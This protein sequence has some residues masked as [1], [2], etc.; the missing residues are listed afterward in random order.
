MLVSHLNN[1][2]YAFII[3][4]IITKIRDCIFLADDGG[5]LGA[6]TNGKSHVISSFSKDYSVKFYI[7]LD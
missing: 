4:G 5:V 6:H 7:G 3:C 2:I 1:C